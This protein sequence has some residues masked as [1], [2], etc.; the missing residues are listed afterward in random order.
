MKHVQQWSRAHVRCTQ[1]PMVTTPAPTR[2]SPWGLADTSHTWPLQGE[3]VDAFM[4]RFQSKDTATAFLKQIGATEK[5]LSLLSS[6]D[7]DA[8]R[9]QHGPKLARRLLSYLWFGKR[10]LASDAPRDPDFVQ[11]KALKETCDA[12]TDV[13]A[14]GHEHFGFCRTRHANM[15]DDVN[16]FTR[17]M[18]YV[19]KDCRAVLAGCSFTGNLKRSKHMS[20]SAIWLVVNLTTHRNNCLIAG[21]FSSSHRTCQG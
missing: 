19:A 16:L 10:V 5:D 18:G 11:A 3:V 20:S 9:K 17:K 15:Q 12:S 1:A 2:M 6:I 13:Q 8:W 4:C 21:S 14:C 7:A